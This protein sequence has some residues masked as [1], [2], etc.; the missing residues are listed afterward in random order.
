MRPC[1]PDLG[2]INPVRSE[3]HYRTIRSSSCK[4]TLL[5]NSGLKMNRLTATKQY[6]LQRVTSSRGETQDSFIQ[7]TLRTV[8]LWSINELWMKIVGSFLILLSS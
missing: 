5:Q 8:T 2:R 1:V 6:R 4:T 3:H 7:E